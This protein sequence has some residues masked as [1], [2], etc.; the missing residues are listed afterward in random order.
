M[1]AMIRGYQEAGCEVHVL[2]MN[3]TRHYVSREK[4]EHLYPE[5]AGFHCVEVDNTISKAR[6]LKNLLLSREPE[7]LKRFISKAFA[8]RLSELIE[9]IKPDFVQLESPF[10]ASY[11]P[12]LRKQ[13]KAI[14]AYRMHNV[15]AQIWQRLADTTPGMKRWYLQNLAQRMSN[16]ERQLWA[17]VDLLI[18]I[19]GADARMVKAA[20]INTPVHVAGIGFDLGAISQKRPLTKPYKLYHIGAMDWQPNVEAMRWFL[21]A[22]W[23]EIHASLPQLN[24]HFAGRAMP[25]E[26]FG[27]LPEGAYCEGEVESAEDFTADKDILIVPLKSGGGIRVKVLEALAQ[28]KLVISTEVGIQGID[29][30]PKMHF[31]KA[32]SVM[33]IVDALQWT[34][35]HPRLAQCVAEDGQSFVRKH[36]NAT[37]ILASLVEQVSSMVEASATLRVH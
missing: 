35:V 16:F 27:P 21:S 34:V 26:L 2:A 22:V 10:L 14:I 6:I 37:E 23:P 12:Q 29:V 11:I 7:H 31:L 5:I 4:V 33:E 3:T 17:D 20:G 24:F 8:V 36:Y 9:S 18:P 28:G 32:N 30:L 19:T 15:E 25:K 13:T 1:D